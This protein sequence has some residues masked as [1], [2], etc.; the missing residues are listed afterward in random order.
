[1][2]RPRCIESY[3]TSCFRFGSLDGCVSTPAPASLFS[4]GVLR[5]SRASLRL[6]VRKRESASLKNGLS[7]PS[8]GQ[9]IGSI[10][11]RSA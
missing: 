9:Q 7:T 8:S 4:C 1:M 3:V 11:T 5:S 2:S 10:E 6:T